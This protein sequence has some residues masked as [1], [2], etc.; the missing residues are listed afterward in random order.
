MKITGRLTNKNLAD[1][2][3][4]KSKVKFKVYGDGNKY[5]FYVK[6]TGNGYFATE[7]NTK[8]EKFTDVSIPLKSLSAR[9]NTKVKKIDLDDIVFAQVVPV[10]KEGKAPVCNAYFFDFE[11]E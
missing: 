1:A 10:G 8:E 11:V 2:I 6:T 7:F 9:V 5:M 3:K 4:N